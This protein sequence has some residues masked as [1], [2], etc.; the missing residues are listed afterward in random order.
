MKKAGTKHKCEIFHCD[1]QGDR[2]PIF[3]YWSRNFG[4]VDMRLMC[5]CSIANTGEFRKA[6]SDTT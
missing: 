5:S 2:Y 1:K 3:Q 6:E 4:S